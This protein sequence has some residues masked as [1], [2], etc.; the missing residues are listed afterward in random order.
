MLESSESYDNDALL[1][2]WSSHLPQSYESY[3]YYERPCHLMGLWR[4]LGGPLWLHHA[5]A[6][7]HHH[8]TRWSRW[9]FEWPLASCQALVQRIGCSLQIQLP[10]D[11]HVQHE[12]WELRFLESSVYSSLRVLCGALS[13]SLVIIPVVDLN[14]GVFTIQFSLRFVCGFLSYSIKIFLFRSRRYNKTQR[15]SCNH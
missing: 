12:R 4:T 15:D 6:G 5:H 11:D 8:A 10:E 14:L 2:L 7:S 3:E 13:S 9:E 1:F